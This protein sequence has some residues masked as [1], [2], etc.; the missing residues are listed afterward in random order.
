MRDTHGAHTNH[1]LTRILIA[2]GDRWVRQ[3]LRT[4]VETDETLL[5]V[6]EATNAQQLLTLAHST[7]PQVII[8]DLL[9][10][11]AQDGLNVITQLVLDQFYEIIVL[12]AATGWHQS[13]VD[14]GATEF[15]D[16]GLGADLVLTTIR[17]VVLGARSNHRPE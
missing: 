9:L 15:L 2:D 16:K 4:L 7:N 13:A 11:T 12:T 10:P 1:D 8:L 14:C 17:A 5:I 6:G 3:A